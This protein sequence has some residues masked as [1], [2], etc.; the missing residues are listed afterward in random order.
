MAFGATRGLLF[1]LTLNVAPGDM[2]HP[3]GRRSLS[4]ADS[5]HCVAAARFLRV[6]QHMSALIDADTI[7]DWRTARR[8]AGCRVTAAGATAIGVA[9]EAVRLYEQLRAAGWHRTPDPRDAPHEASLRFRWRR[10]DC[11]FNVYDEARLGTDAEFRVNEL[12]ATPTG[13]T[14]Y[15]VLTLCLPAMAATPD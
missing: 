4:A 9:R 13:N 10:T 1:G 3:P 6:E 7:D 2:L 8:I 14:R 12:A 5:T 11:L 15:Q